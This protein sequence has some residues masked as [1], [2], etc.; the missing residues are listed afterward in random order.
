M[1]ELSLKNETRCAKIF[2]V[3]D[4]L[5]KV[6]RCFVSCMRHGPLVHKPEM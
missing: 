1:S 3:L 2:H 5:H 4:L 6:W